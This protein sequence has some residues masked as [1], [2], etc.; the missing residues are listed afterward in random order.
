MESRT[1]WI[2]GGIGAAAVTIITTVLVTVYMDDIKEVLGYSSS[3]K[4]TTPVDKDRGPVLTTSS[5]PAKA[6]KAGTKKPAATK[7]KV[8]VQKPAKKTVKEPATPEE[9]PL[10]LREAERNNRCAELPFSYE[11]SKGDPDAKDRFYKHFWGPNYG[12][13]LAGAHDRRMPGP[14][15]QV[16]ARLEKMSP[17]RF[18]RYQARLEKIVRKAAC[19]TLDYY[20]STCKEVFDQNHKN[21]LNNDYLRVLLQRPASL[22]DVTPIDR[23]RVQRAKQKH[24]KVVKPTTSAEPP[25]TT[26]SADKPRQ[27]RHLRVSLKTRQPRLCSNKLKPCPK[28]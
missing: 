19:R 22:H 24:T 17:N 3:P 1:K 5:K 27:R 20:L 14:V 25:A 9:K 2:A 28:P 7:K 6:K 26:D 10:A 23:Y 16:R 21:Y 13:F 8:K 18:A 12:C 15:P 4:A 11:F